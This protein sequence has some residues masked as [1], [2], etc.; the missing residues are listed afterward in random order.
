MSHEEE[1]EGT[2]QEGTVHIGHE[3]RSVRLW[4][5][6]HLCLV[7]RFH[8]ASVHN[9]HCSLLGVYVIHLLFPRSR[10]MIVPTSVFSAP[11]PCLTSS[12]AF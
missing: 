1:K 6:R 3:L 11:P 8:N 12:M 10:S 4:L 9:A 5:D 7:V 2:V